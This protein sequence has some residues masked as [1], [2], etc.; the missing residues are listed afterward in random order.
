MRVVIGEDQALFRQGMA[1]LLE[2]EG[3]EVVAEAGD[4]DELCA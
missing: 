3:Y 2:H 4:A 1:S